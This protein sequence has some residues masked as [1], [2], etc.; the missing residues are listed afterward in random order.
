MLVKCLHYSTSYPS[1]G[2][3]VGDI[4]DISKAQVEYYTQL[5]WVEAL[6]QELQPKK[7]RG[8]QRKATDIPL[9]M[10]KSP[11]VDRNLQHN[12]SSKRLNEIN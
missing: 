11:Q 8:K 2:Q 3:S 1:G 9:D 12:F 5:G 10:S 6:P 7:S 4:F